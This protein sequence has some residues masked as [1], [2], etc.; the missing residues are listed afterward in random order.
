M[1]NPLYSTPAGLL[2]ELLLVP[3]IVLDVVI[4]WGG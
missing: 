1:T 3:D 4:G 2:V